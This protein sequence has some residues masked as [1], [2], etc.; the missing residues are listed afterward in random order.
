MA[1]ETKSIPI[2]NAHPTAVRAPRKLVFLIPLTYQQKYNDFE[3][4]LKCG[5]DDAKEVIK[6]LKKI[7]ITKSKTLNIFMMNEVH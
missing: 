7:T 3:N 6:M 1:I 2:E 5:I 4:W